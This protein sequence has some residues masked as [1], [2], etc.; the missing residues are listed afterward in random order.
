METKAPINNFTKLL[1]NIHYSEDCTSYRSL[2]LTLTISM[3]G[4]VRSA[5]D[6]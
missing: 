1:P 5:Q 2:F 6:F 3:N 4:L